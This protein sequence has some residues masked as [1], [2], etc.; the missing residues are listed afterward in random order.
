MRAVGNWWVLGLGLAISV[1]CCGN[2]AEPDG[3]GGRSGAGSSGAS[4][5]AAGTGG[6]SGALHVPSGDAGSAGSSDA[7]NAGSLEAGSPGSAGTAASNGS[8]AGSGGARFGTSGNGGGGASSGGTSGSGGLSSGGTG[9]GTAGTSGTAGTAGTGGASTPTCGAAPYARGYLAAKNIVPPLPAG[10]FTLSPSLCPTKSVT[11]D[12][13]QAKAMDVPAGTAIFLRGS[14]SGSYPALS[15]EYKLVAGAAGAQVLAV[16]L[17]ATSVDFTV[18]DSNWSKG[19]E[20]VVNLVT[21]K[22]PGALDA[23]ADLT[24]IKYSV[25][26]HPETIAIYSGT[27]VATS[28]PSTSDAMGSAALFIK[29]KGTLAIPEMVQIVGNKMGCSLTT[30]DV[31]KQTGRI[32]VGGGTTSGTLTAAIGN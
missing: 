26:G 22:Q 5:H 4:G 21:I 32:P 6:H 11:T 15:P 18:A 3:S 24:G 16:S 31:S 25:V 20:A 1:P 7:G 12:L 2:E 23:C 19:N 28:T 17:V 13:G 29:T 9:G 30:V 8:E 14:Q 27:S 10:P